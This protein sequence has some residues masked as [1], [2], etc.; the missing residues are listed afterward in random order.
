M[1]Q[2]VV[3][4]RVEID[5]PAL[6]QLAKLDRQIRDRIRL[7]IRTLADNPRPPGCKL[8]IGRPG[9]RIKVGKDWRVIYTVNDGVALVLVIELGHRRE[10]YR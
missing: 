1:I 3:P 5:A 4:Y 8:L 2:S 7:A 10:I 9:Y 6:K